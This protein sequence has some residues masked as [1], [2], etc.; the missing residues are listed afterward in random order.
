MIVRELKKHKVKV[1]GLQE[2][3]WFGSKGYNV[4]GTVLLTSNQDKPTD[5]QKYERSSDCSHR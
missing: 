3:K 5:D 2:T 1:A 4:A